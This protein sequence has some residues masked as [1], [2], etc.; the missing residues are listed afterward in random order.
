M[1]QLNG[2]I[3]SAA[4]GTSLHTLVSLLLGVTPRVGA[5]IRI[6]PPDRDAGCAIWLDIA[7]GAASIDYSTFLITDAASP[8]PDEVGVPATRALCKPLPQD[9]VAALR[10]QRTKRP[11]ASTLGA[12][13]YSETPHS[14]E[15]PEKEEAVGRLRST[16]HRALNG[17]AAL[18]LR[19]G[20]D[21]YH[22]SLIATAPEICGRSR[23]YYLRCHTDNYL[24]DLDR[25]YAAL[26]LGPAVQVSITLEF[27]SRVVPDDA[28][29][30]WVFRFLQERVEEA[31]PRKRYTLDALLEFHNWFA[32]ATGFML[33]FMLGLR[34]QET[35]DIDASRHLDG[36]HYMD[37]SDKCSGEV[38]RSLPVLAGPIARQQLALV[39]AHL[40]DLDRRASVLGV[41]ATVGWRKDVRAALDRRAVPLLFVVRGSKSVA[42][43]TSML[44]EA[45]PPKH[46]PVKNAGRHYWQTY[47]YRVGLRSD[48]IDRWARHS[49]TALE[50][51][52]SHTVNVD[53]A[54]ASRLLAEQHQKAVSLGIRAIRGLTTRRNAL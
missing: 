43:G 10:R 44:F 34:V 33:A 11:G 17:L 23:L 40:R 53:D 1:K 28:D 27:G 41:P 29:I 14:T 13:C 6:G 26:G 32:T 48:D 4:D 38:R 2:A 5:D 22:A 21:R 9:L 42:I 25:Y 30:Q 31:R 47:L 54:V 19:L 51:C 49:P 36:V 3:N 18:A 15:S 8:R 12:L 39:R 16:P 7:R 45:L 52:A 46:K 50:V 20:I 37:T 35:L 24:R